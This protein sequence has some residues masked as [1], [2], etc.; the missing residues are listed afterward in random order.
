MPVLTAEID[1]R[2]EG[3]LPVTGSL[4]SVEPG[5]VMVTALKP[6]EVGRA[7]VVRLFSLAPE[8]TEAVLDVRRLPVR[9]AALANLVEEHERDLAIRDGRVRV[10]VAP[11]RP[12]T[13]ILR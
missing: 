2:Q 4:L 12:V 7:L 3:P 11:L 10:P 5:S 13:V 8:P 6:A 1:R 9:Q